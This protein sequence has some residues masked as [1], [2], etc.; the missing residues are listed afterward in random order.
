MSACLLLLPSLKPPIQPCLLERIYPPIT[1]LLCVIFP[2]YS[3]WSHGHFKIL[4][5]EHIYFS[6]MKIFL[7]VCYDGSQGSFAPYDRLLFQGHSPLLE[8]THQHMVL[9]SPRVRYKVES[10][11]GHKTPVPMMHITHFTFLMGHFYFQRNQKP[12]IKT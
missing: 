10:H 1:E 6:L 11:I 12:M 9:R 5:A 2:L 3:D 7:W 4:L 8:I